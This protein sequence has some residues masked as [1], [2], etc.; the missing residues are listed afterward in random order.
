MSFPRRDE[1]VVPRELEAFERAYRLLAG[2]ADYLDTARR[3]L[4]PYMKADS[5]RR[6]LGEFVRGL[7]AALDRSG[8]DL[9]AVEGGGT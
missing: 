8:P 3:E 5:Y 9:E 2:R 1:A 4:R 6:A 7:P